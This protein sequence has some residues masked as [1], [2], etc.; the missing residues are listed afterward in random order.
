MA[1]QIVTKNEM[2]IVVASSI[3]LFLA[4]FAIIALTASHFISTTG[5][6]LLGFYGS[7]IIF[8]LIYSNFKSKF[9]KI[10]CLR[11]STEN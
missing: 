7:V 10:G 5:S 2:K 1:K 3:T 6:A 4:L 11:I 8:Q 9:Q